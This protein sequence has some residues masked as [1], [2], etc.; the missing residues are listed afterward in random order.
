MSRVNSLE[1]T[2]MQE[3]IEGRREGDD[4]GWDGWMASLTQWAWV[5]SRS[6]RQGRTGKP[7][8][9]QPIGSQ[10]VGQVWVTEQQQSKESYI[11]SHF[12]VK[13]VFQSEFLCVCVCVRVYITVVK[14]HNTKRTSLT[15]FSCKVQSHLH[16]HCYETLTIIHLLNYSSS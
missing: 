5:W 10:R 16:S 14:S 4:R 6:R 2:L 3:K 12:P 11:S 15:I 13:M 9:L 1:K 7:G 8:V